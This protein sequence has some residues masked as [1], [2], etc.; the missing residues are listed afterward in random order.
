MTYPLKPELIVAL[1][2]SRF[3]DAVAIVR[4]LSLRVT[5]Y[6]VG[7]ELFSAEG[8]GIL[9]HLQEYEGKKIFL[10]LK[11]HD[12]PNTIARAVDC[13]AKNGAGLLTVHA[14]GGGTML[15][16][17]VEAAR[18]WG[19][20]APQLIAVTTLTNLGDED[21]RTIGVQSSVLEY[22][23]SLAR[24]ALASGMDG[25]V[26]AVAEAAVLRSEFGPKPVL[27]TPGIRPQGTQPGD[28]KRIATP[29]AAVR[30]GVN[31]LVVGRPVL[32]ASDPV[33]AVQTILD[34]ITLASQS[35]KTSQPPP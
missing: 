19:P 12:I 34:E 27:V 20:R 15:K 28:Q 31:F 7:L 23:R 24:L 3:E 8:P 16:A 11:L 10:D 4:K 17:A 29:S 9:R 14:Q 1:D 32:A 18:S 21:L 13:A 33:R 22:S 26:C 5:W 25:L 35:G 30:A 2:V 6:K